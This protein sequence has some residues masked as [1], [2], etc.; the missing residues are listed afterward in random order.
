MM[1]AKKKKSKNTLQMH[2]KCKN[3]ALQAPAKMLT[4]PQRVSQRSFWIS[5]KIHLFQQWAHHSS[6]TEKNGVV[7]L[8][9]WQF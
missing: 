9:H 8:D 2:M 4:C 6:C 5:T 3:N 1:N 7:G